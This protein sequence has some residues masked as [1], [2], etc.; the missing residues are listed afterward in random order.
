[1]INV[2]LHYYCTWQTALDTYGLNVH[3]EGLEGASCLYYLHST[4]ST[5]LFLIAQFLNVSST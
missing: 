1:M 2:I 4:K 5:F 3:K